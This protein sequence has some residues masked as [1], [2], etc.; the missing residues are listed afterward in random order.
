MASEPGVALSSVDERSDSHRMIR[1]WVAPRKSRC[2]LFIDR[3]R[4]LSHEPGILKNQESLPRCTTI[5]VP[6]GLSACLGAGGDRHAYATA[7]ASTPTRRRSKFID[8]RTSVSSDFTTQHVEVKS[9][10]QVKPPRSEILIIRTRFTATFPVTDDCSITSTTAHHRANGSARSTTRRRRYYV[11]SS[12]CSEAG[13]WGYVG[14]PWSQDSTAHTARPRTP[15]TRCSTHG[16]PK[17]S[18]PIRRNEVTSI[19]NQWKTVAN[20]TNKSRPARRLEPRFDPPS[21]WPTNGLDVAVWCC[22]AAHR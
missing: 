4:R 22:A 5:K 1:R 17:I 20:V 19:L 12:S 11:D 2:G 6:S 9:S 10:M 13:G 18:K 7:C 16:A 3:Y 8:G 21:T 14:T 15:S